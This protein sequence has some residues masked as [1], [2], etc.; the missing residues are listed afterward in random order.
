M[1]LKTVKIGIAMEQRIAFRDAECGDQAINSLAYGDPA[2]LEH[3]KVLRSLEG[4]TRRHTFKNRERQKLFL[5][6][7]KFLIGTEAAQDLA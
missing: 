6:P 4:E 5:R 1:E 3:P 7:P 2:P